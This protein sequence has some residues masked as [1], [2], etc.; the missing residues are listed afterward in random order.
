M[1][2]LIDGEHHPGVVRDALDRLA[3]EHELC[4]VLFVGGEE[5]LTKDVL[6]DP[7]RHYGRQVAIAS[8]ASIVGV[9]AMLSQTGAS[10]VVDLSG[11]PVLD[12]SSRFRLASVALQRGLEYTTAGLRLSPPP[13][14]RLAFGRPVIA[15]I[16]T[17][18]RTGKTAVAGHYATLLRERGLEPVVLAMGRGGPAEPQLVRREEQPDLARLLEIFRS[19]GHAASDYL[20]DAVLAEV[21]CVGC[22]RCGEGLAGEPLDTNLRDGAGLALSLDPDVLLVEGSGAALPPIEADRTVCVTSAVDAG[23]QALSFLGPIRLL[24]SHLVAI[25]GAGDLPPAELAGLKRA[26]REW[27]QEASL[28]ACELRPEPAGA[29]P[30]GARVALFTTA[31][32]NRER[33]IR[34]SLKQHGVEVRVFS[35]G[36]A[37]REELERDLRRAGDERCDFFLTELKA[38]AIELVATNAEKS[39]VALGFLRNRPVSLPGEPS[40]DEELLRLV[41]EARDATR[42]PAATR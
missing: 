4:D 30:G 42:E 31:P 8:G 33:Q 5:K 3:L 17:G 22:R 12:G 39:G 40:L 9:G 36:L 21:S 35:S 19:G 27:C 25:I 11:E 6:A 28:V 41:Q 2:A 38:A 10:A 1:V 32:A 7:A 26:L 15:A 14:E 37:R 13:A 20:E 16:G 18:K 34:A 29:V 23:R 24:R